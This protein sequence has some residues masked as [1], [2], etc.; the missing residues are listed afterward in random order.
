MRKL[1]IK[2]IFVI[3]A[4]MVLGGVAEA[5]PVRVMPSFKGGSLQDFKAWVMRK[6]ELTKE[7]KMSE[8]KAQIL[9]YVNSEGVVEQVE[10]VSATDNQIGQAYCKTVESSPKWQPAKQNGKAVGVKMVLPIGG[11]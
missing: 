1:L 4:A 11:R 10:L 8:F 9:F 6:V 7:Q 5:Q 2:K 3:C